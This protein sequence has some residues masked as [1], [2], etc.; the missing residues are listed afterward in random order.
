MKSESKAKKYWKR[1]SNKKVRHAENVPSGRAFKKI[2][3]TYNINDYVS[4][5]F[6]GNNHYFDDREYL[7][8]MK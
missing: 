3:D 1:E 2:G 8:T 6:G 7:I 4:K 5:C